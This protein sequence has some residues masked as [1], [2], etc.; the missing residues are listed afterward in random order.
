MR[1][2]AIT[3]TPL[4]LTGLL[5]AGCADGTSGTGGGLSLPDCPAS[6]NGAKDALLILADTRSQRGADMVAARLDRTRLFLRTA[7][8]CGATVTVDWS[9]GQS[10]VTN[11]YSGPV[12]KESETDV[13]TAKLSNKLINEKV[14][15]AI[16]AGVTEATKKDAPA[17]SSPAGA[18][19][20]ARDVFAAG[21]GQ[22]AVLVI[23]DN[24]VTESEDERQ[25][26]NTPSFDTAKAHA[27]AATVAVPKLAGVVVA[28]E[29]VG[30]TV[31]PTPAPD[32]YLRAVR[33]YADALC[34]KTTATCVPSLTQ[35]SAEG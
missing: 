6:W 29:G 1:R 21:E 11:L 7:A 22:P 19:D 12:R 32:D 20:V 18:F 23:L 14:M 16:S 9:Q 8:A 33:E 5:V 4:V 30:L 25:N 28:I 13:G 31:D 26:V 27:L 2:T 10:R 15:P 17:G 3:L 24:F 34:A 35:L